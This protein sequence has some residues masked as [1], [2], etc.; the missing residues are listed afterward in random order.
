MDMLN[1]IVRNQGLKIHFAACVWGFVLAVASFFA[2]DVSLEKEPLRLGPGLR[3]V[4]LSLVIL[5]SHYLLWLY[6]KM[7]SRRISSGYCAVL[8]FGSWAIFFLIYNC[9]I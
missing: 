7:L 3:L 4:A 1:S 9:L 6:G 5:W 8:F 2:W